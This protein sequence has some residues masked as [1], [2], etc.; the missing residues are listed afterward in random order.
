MS[1]HIFFGLALDDNAFPKSSQTQGGV[2]YL[3]PKGILY[4]LESHLGLV[5]YSNNN[6]Y[7][8]VEQY[9]QGIQLFLKNQ[10]SPFFKASFEADQFA[11]ATELL[12]RRDEL[13]LAGWNFQINE[14]IPKRLKALVQI[15][16]I[17]QKDDFSFEYGYADRYNIILQ[18]LEHIPNPIQR[19]QLIEDRSILPYY[20]LRL[21]NKLNE[22]GTQ[23]IATPS[24]VHEATKSDLHLFQN[25]LQSKRAGK[26]EAK[27]F[28]ADGSLILLRAKRDT[29]LAAY[30]AKLLAKNPG[31]Q[32][33]CL[34]S[35]D[36]RIIDHAFVQEG[37]PSMGTLS[38]SLARPTLQVL[39]LITVFL[40][41]PIDP[42]KI[43]EFVSLAVKPLE[44]ELANRIAIQMAQRPGLNS[45]SWRAMVAAYFEEMAKKAEEDTSIALDEIRFQYRTWFERKR[46]EASSKVPKEDVI[47]IFAYLNQWAFR[48]FEKGGGENASLLVLSEQAKRIRELLEALPE[49]QLSKLELERIVRTIY[50]PAPI[51]FT[52]AGIRHLPTVNA[53]SAI[54]DSVPSLLWWT[55]TQHERDH[56]FSKWYQSERNYLEQNG[57]RLSTPAEENAIQIWQRKQAILHTK[58]RLILLLPQMINGSNVHAHPLLGDLEANFSNLE[59]IT[60]HLDV[61]SNLNFLARFFE[62]PQRNA[63]ALIQLGQPKP[64]LYLQTNTPLQERSEET[65]SSLETLFYYPYQ[66]IFRH[67][68]KLQKSSI[69]EVVKDNTL[70]GNLAHRFFERLLQQDIEQMDQTAVHL[71]VE[72][73]AKSLL[74][75]EGAVLLMYGREPQRVHFLNIIK[76]A[77]WSLIN[78]IRQ[79]NWNVKGSEVKLQGRFF[80][81]PINGRADLVLKRASETAIIDLK[82]RGAK[83]RERTIRNEEDLQL[84]LY[85]KLLED[86]QHWAHTAYFIIEKGQIISRNEQAFKDINALVPEQDHVEIYDRILQKM[87]ATF[88]WRKQQI[89]EGKIEV[90]C[91]QTK[92][93]LEEE[94]GDILLDLL[95]MKEDDAFYDDYRTLINL[96]E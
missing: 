12:N 27:T 29:D 52:P 6:E 23:I 79:N 35:N 77:A 16:Q 36:G 30:A 10:V 1:M 60:V 71:W 49:S 20:L 88:E 95:E 39:K 82:W 45:D 50:E 28:H 24:P 51:Q 67:K 2:A 75:R 43:L 32:P 9:R 81:I 19:L 5:G 57:I 34:L 22:L 66:W 93:D 69:L 56:F 55:F 94:Y 31:F 92:Q 84:V 61:H 63:S 44:E 90:R 26:T 87:E 46:Y 80:N 58:D 13:S 25:Q 48:N 91:A 83:R 42:F 8:R 53:P 89:Q 18:K 64:F 7:L 41:N 68:I 73:E 59:D 85:A 74:E 62:L 11:T 72:K 17:I 78:S 86:N 65:I 33:V 4:F 40:W 21:L 3:G 76:Y 70:L 47:E 96:L 15:E 38:A 37:L 14:A 54:I